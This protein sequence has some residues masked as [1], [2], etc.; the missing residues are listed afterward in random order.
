MDGPHDLGGKEGFGPIVTDEADVP[1]HHDWEGRMWGISRS[2]GA[3]G[4]T[5]D[6]WRHVRELIDPVDYLTRPY[7]DSWAQT[8][9]ATYIDAGI[10]TLDEVKAGRS[11]SAKK[12]KAKVV[13]VAE[14]IAQDGANR[15]SFERTVDAAPRFAPGDSVLTKPFTQTHHTRLPAYARGKPGKVH[16]HHGAHVF[17]DENAK[18]NDV[19]QHLY[20][21]VFEA[22]A[23]WPEAGTRRDRIFL[24]LWESYLE[25]S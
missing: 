7:Y 3:P 1:F 16:A 20:S 9:L 19:A 2:S 6:W 15:T 4:V 5:I 8:E 18:G 21:V 12:R 25:P 22:K 14:A 13:S 11:A 17:A 10:I 24:D 23:L